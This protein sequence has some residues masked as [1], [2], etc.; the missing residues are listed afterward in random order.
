MLLKVLH[1]KV[2]LLIFIAALLL[3]VTVVH[4]VV[5]QCLQSGKIV[6]WKYTCYR[7]RTRGYETRIPVCEEEINDYTQTYTETERLIFEIG[8]IIVGSI[9]DTVVGILLCLQ[10]VDVAVEAITG[11]IDVLEANET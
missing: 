9:A 8:L 2:R 1:I 6:I 10:L 7:I 5:Q 4:Q 3:Y 11:I